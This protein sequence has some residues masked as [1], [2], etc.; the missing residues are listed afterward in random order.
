MKRIKFLF[1]AAVVITALLAASVPASAFS[2]NESRSIDNFFIEAQLL[3]GDGTGYGLDKPANRLEGIVILIR[4]MGQD[5]EAQNMKNLPCRFTDVPDWAKGYVNYADAGNLSKGVSDTLFGGNDQLTACQYNA[6]LLRVLGYDDSKGDFRWDDSVD[7][8]EELGIL[9]ADFVHDSSQSKIAFTK[10]A[11]MKTSF[12]YLQAKFKDQE[13]TLADRLIEN[14]AISGDLAEEYGLSVKKW[15]ELSTNLGDGET[16]SFHL[17]DGILTVSGRSEDPEK[18]WLLVRINN[19]ETGKNFKET[20]HRRNQ[21]GTY[22]FPVSVANLPKGEYDIDL[23][24]NDEKY[25]L[26]SGLIHSSLTLKVAAGD[27]YLVPPPVYGENLRFFKGDQL[28]EEDQAFTLET[29]ADKDGLEEIRALSADITKDCGSDYEKLRAIHDW[30]AGNIYY[31]LDY[32]NNKKASSNESSKSV[33]E[34]RLAACGGYS[35]LTKD[36]LAAAG[37]PCK[38][39][40]GYALGI[41]EEDWGDVNLRR[42][43]PNHA[44]NEAYVDGRWII[45]DTTWDT[46]NTCENGTFTKGHRVS[47]LYFDSTVEFFSNSHKSMKDVKQ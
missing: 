46:R 30:V 6:L 10:G 18:E 4:L 38:V 36:L 9:P 27:S 20:P 47:R 25:N 26:Y 29:R 44:W 37:I 22:D 33:L 11:L 15:D 8:A 45:L 43:K 19:T 41:S 32:L 35:N 40:Y 12:C 31:D 14:G 7:K 5:A 1:A 28:D 42:L 34:N 23:Y 2:P 39:I 17:D 24:Y 3:K 21:D 13:Q 16:F